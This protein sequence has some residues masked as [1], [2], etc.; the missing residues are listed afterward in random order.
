MTTKKMIKRS[1][2]GASLGLRSLPLG[3]LDGDVL[4]LGALLGADEG[5]F[6]DDLLLFLVLLPAARRGV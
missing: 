1:L 3:E 2:M 5:S 4:A 6:D